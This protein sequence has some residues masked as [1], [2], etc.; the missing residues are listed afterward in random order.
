MVRPLLSLFFVVRPERL[1]HLRAGH[2]VL[3][4]DRGEVGGE[5]LG[6][7]ETNALLLLRRRNLLARSLRRL[8]LVNALRPLAARVLHDLLLFL[9]L[10]LLLLGL[11]LLFLLLGLLLL[12]LLGLLRLLRRLL[13]RLLLGR[14]LLRPREGRLGDLLLHLRKAQQHARGEKHRH[15]PSSGLRQIQTDISHLRLALGIHMLPTAS[16]PDSKDPSYANCGL[17]LW[18]WVPCRSPQRRSQAQAPCSTAE[19][20]ALSL[21]TEPKQ[22]MSNRK[23]RKDRSAQWLPLRA[24]ACWS[25]RMQL[26][27]VLSTT[28]WSAFASKSAVPCGRQRAQSCPRR[29]LLRARPPC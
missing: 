7:E 21:R 25:S 12:R 16:R 6:G 13:R 1:H 3:A 24:Q 15:H 8:A 4:A 18:R 27:R 10:F 29:I 2:L 19:S 9:L 23:K 20:Q 22:H 17:Q 28:E 14:R 26:T 11:L 5:R